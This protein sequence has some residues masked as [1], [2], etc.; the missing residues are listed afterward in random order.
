[1]NKT[2][3]NAIRP[4]SRTGYSE[5]Q[6]HRLLNQWLTLLL[7]LSWV[8]GAASSA[9]GQVT[10]PTSTS[11]HQL[12][13]MVVTATVA[14]TPLSLTTASVSVIS[15]EQIASQQAESV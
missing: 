6:L 11:T 2:G 3:R 1:M 14:P 10:A 9:L 7:V 4:R 13:P 12:E 8:G 5:K 15:R